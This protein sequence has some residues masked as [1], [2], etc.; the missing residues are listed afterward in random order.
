MAR[1][2]KAKVTARTDSDDKD[3]TEAIIDT[4]DAFEED[5]ETLKGVLPKQEYQ[6]L[7]NVP[8]ALPA[9]TPAP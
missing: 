6:V 8:S 3:R 5:Y 2:D 9:H 7:V 1:Q 4:M